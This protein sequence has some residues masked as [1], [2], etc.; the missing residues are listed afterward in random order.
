MAARS[1]RDAK[2]LGLDGPKAEVLGR[3]R[4]RKAPQVFEAGAAVCFT[5]QKIS[6]PSLLDIEP[7]FNDSWETERPSVAVARS[8]KHRDRKQAMN[9]CASI[10]QR[11]RA[12][13]EKHASEIADL[14]PGQG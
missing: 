12:S 5:R 13:A 1:K 2:N 10:L 9:Q 4:V 14:V 8:D 3:G 6:E 11:A 7:Y